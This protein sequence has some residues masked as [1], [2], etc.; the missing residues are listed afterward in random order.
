MSEPIFVDAAPEIVA[1]GFIFNILFNIFNISTSYYNHNV[2]RRLEI[3]TYFLIPS[4]IISTV[5]LGLLKSPFK[6]KILV[7]LSSPPQIV[8]YF[9]AIF[10]IILVEIRLIIVLS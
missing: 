4:Y 3:F 7:I 10:S 2:L 9:Q 6:D 1:N 5:L 8:L